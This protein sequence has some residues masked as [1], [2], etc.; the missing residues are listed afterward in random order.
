[1]T[2]FPLRFT[3]APM[4]PLPAS[5]VPHNRLAAECAAVHRVRADGRLLAT[6]A[7]SIPVEPVR[8]RPRHGDGARV[9]GSVARAASTVVVRSWRQARAVAGGAIPTLF[10]LGRASPEQEE[11]PEKTC[12]CG[13]LHQR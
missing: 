7:V 12:D 9:F 10:F 11:N 6:N 2:S 5:R 8:V 4:N 3:G 13:P 1:M